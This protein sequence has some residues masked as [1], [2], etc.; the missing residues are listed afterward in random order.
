MPLRAG[1]RGRRA[2]ARPRLL[3]DRQRRLRRRER[4]LRAD[5]ARAPPRARGRT[6]GWSSRSSGKSGVE[7]RI[8]IDDPAVIEALDVMRRR[9]GGDDRLLACKD[10]RSLAAARLRAGQ[11]LRPRDDRAARPPPRT[12]APG[13]PPCSRRP[14]W[15]R[16]TEPGETKASRKRAVAGGDE[17]GRGVPRQHPD[18]GPLVVRRPAR[19]STPTRRAGRSQRRHPAYLR[20]RRRAPGRPG[21]GRRC[22]L[23]DSDEHRTWRSR[24][25]RATSPQQDV[26]AVVNAA[27]RAMRGGGGV[28]GAIHRAGGPAVLEDCMRALP[29][30]GSPPATPAGRPPGDMPARWVIHVVGPNRTAGE[31]D[32]VAAHLL[33]R[34]RARGRRRARRPHGRVPAGQR[35][36]LRLAARTTRS[37]PPSRRSG[38][39]PTRGRGGPA[40]GV[41]RD[42][43]R[44]TQMRD[45]A[46][47]A[48]SSEPLAR[49][50]R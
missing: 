30:T 22:R 37:P 26:D 45:A 9:R 14:R 43:R 17:G 24:S 38:R 8:E 39:P 7:H 41:R 47:D 32:R 15:P 46:A 35:R 29:A 48:V 4:Q 40:G 2:A 5:H 21:A 28:D 1:L 49:A 11:R 50:P 19:R 6:T 34:P 3:P 20:H 42:V 36:R 23:L 12:S 27:N 16:P 33:L 13:T 18:A 31:T 44:T 25:S 10:G